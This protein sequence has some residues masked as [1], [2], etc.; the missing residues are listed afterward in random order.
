MNVLVRFPDHL[1]K[2]ELG[3]LTRMY[4]LNCA[5]FMFDKG[6]GVYY[7]NTLNYKCA[8]FTVQV[9]GEA[10]H[11]DCKNIA[12]CRDENHTTGH[13]AEKNS[14][15]LRTIMLQKTIARYTEC[16]TCGICRF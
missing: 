10:P 6:K 16:H 5:G 4:T 14:T 15:L 3:N 8:Q 12:R 11:S 1:V 9:A 2:S 13:V 7:R